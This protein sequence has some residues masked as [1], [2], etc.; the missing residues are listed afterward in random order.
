[1]YAHTHMLALSLSVS[2]HY[3]H[4]NMLYV[5]TLK[6]THAYLYKNTH[7]YILLKSMIYTSTLIHKHVYTHTKDTHFKVKQTHT[8]TL[9]VPPPHPPQL[10]DCT[11]MHTYTTGCQVTHLQPQQVELHDEQGNVEGNDYPGQPHLQMQ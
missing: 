10:V 1:M 7:K 11:R 5:Y 9:S 4:T 3:I 6:D 8:H 2:F